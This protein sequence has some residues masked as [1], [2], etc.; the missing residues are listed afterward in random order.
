VTEADDPV[1]ALASA[2]VR[3]ASITPE[4]AGCQALLRERLEACGFRVESLRVGTVDNL[5]ARRGDAAPLF[6][7]AGHT[8]VVPTGEASSWRYPPFDATV[9]DGM[10]HG[11]GAADMKGS[12]A[13]MVVATERVLAEGTPLQG[14]IGFLITSD[15]EGPA[16]DGTRA[17]MRELGR[18]GVRI[19]QCLVGEPSSSRI[20]GDV[21]R[22]GRRGSLNGTLTVKGI[23]GH[24]AYPDAARNPVHDLLAPLAALAARHWDAGNAYFPATSF[25][26]SNIHAGTGAT[27]VIPGHCTV[28]FNF[29]FSTEQ[30]ADALQAAVAAELETAGLDFEIDWQLSG[31]PFLTEGGA[32]VEAVKDSIRDLSGL[33]PTLSTGGGTSDGRFIAPQGAEVVELGPVNATIHKIDECVAIADLHRLTDAYAQILRRLLGAR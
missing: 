25:Q 13:A 26:V 10:L 27:N 14:S 33:E 4:D 5:W 30:T 3:R 2:L 20:L 28:Q 11:R 23:Q 21:V 29:R 32:L 31:E 8:D 16:V 7:F 9:A 22:V 19:D 24:V 12:L 15:E 6:V 1:L 17:V 18:R